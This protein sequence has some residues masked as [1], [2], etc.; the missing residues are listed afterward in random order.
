[1]DDELGGRARAGDREAFEALLHRHA[2]AML[3]F[4]DFVLHDRSAAEDAVQE[5]YMTA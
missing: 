1:M 5:A 4:A 3:Q 2:R